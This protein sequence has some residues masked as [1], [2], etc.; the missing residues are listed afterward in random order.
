MITASAWGENALVFYHKGLAS[1]LSYK[2]IEYFTKAHQVIILHK[3]RSN[4]LF[5]I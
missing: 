5:L 2:K 4:Y 3:T 1:R